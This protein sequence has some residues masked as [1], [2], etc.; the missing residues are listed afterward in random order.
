MGGAAVCKG[1]E[2][3]RLPRGGMM[4]M[5][6][7][8]MGGPCCGVQGGYSGYGGGGWRLG[9]C[10]AVVCTTDEYSWASHESVMDQSWASRGSVV[11]SRGSSGNMFALFFCRRIL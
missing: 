3:M 11:V 10:G 2:G 7:G 6:G 8:M 1:G 5:G 9:I 4:P